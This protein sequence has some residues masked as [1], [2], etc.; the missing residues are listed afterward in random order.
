MLF[1]SREVNFLSS[2]SI[3]LIGLEC[4]LTPASLSDLRFSLSPRG[5]SGERVGERGS[6]FRLRGFSVPPW[7]A[8]INQPGGLA[9]SS[10]G[11]RS[12]RRYPRLSRLFGTHPG[13]CAR[14]HRCFP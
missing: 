2:L 11:L 10:R 5:T 12:L 6:I 1:V 3:R 8:T 13:G 7:T 9:D 14:D 4:N